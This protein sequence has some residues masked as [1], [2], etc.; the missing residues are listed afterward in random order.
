MT[1]FEL[2]TDEED[3]LKEVANVAMGKAAAQ[4]AELLDTFL[5]LAVPEIRVVQAKD[6]VEVVRKDFTF[7]EKELLTSIRQGFNVGDSFAG[8]AIA[9]FTDPVSQRLAESMGYPG[10]LN[11]RQHAELL[12]D[13]SNILVG[14]C[15]NGISQQLYGQGMTFSA[16]AVLSDG[17][18][19]GEL[20]ELA[21]N[22]RQLGWEYSLFIN[23]RFNIQ[24]ESMRSHL[25]V[26]VSEA[27]ITDVRRA[28]G[29]LLERL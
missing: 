19:I 20:L 12:L 7:S 10:D 15:L 21:F 23:V 18:E 8:E 22:H 5:E 4:L 2:T 6:I 25:L 14:A 26:F 11:R 9:T 28:L 13:I 29:V 17:M 24:A 16:P 27:S 3:L 1:S